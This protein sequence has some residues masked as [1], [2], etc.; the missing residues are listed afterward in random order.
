MAITTVE[1]AQLTGMETGNVSVDVLIHWL[2]P[3]MAILTLPE[4]TVCIIPLPSEHNLTLSSILE[5]CKAR[6]LK[7]NL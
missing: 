2:V 4:V 5:S 6:G 7:P 1:L 3:I